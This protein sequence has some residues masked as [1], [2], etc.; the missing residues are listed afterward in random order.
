VARKEIQN[1]AGDRKETVEIAFTASQ[2]DRV[3][4]KELFRQLQRIRA[5]KAAPAEP[6]RVVNL[7]RQTTQALEPAEKGKAKTQAVDVQERAIRKAQKA[8]R[9]AKAH[10]RQLDLHQAPKWQREADG[11]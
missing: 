10:E 3:Q 11:A 2:S 9:R 5:V 1:R 4:V 8:A 6:E 7:C